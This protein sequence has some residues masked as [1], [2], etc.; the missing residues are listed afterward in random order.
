MF[1]S[2]KYRA[3]ADECGELVK[4]SIDPNHRR[5]LRKLK[6]SFIVL[7]D[8]EER[9]ADNHQSAIRAPEQEPNGATLVRKRNI[10]FDASGQR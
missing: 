10:T 7:P 2:Q 5:D 8:N 4:T 9:L 3:K 1:T 6:Q